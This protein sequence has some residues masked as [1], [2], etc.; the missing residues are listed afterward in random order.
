MKK[1]FLI[2]FAFA[3]TIFAAEGFVLLETKQSGKE[4]IKSLSSA[5]AKAGFTAA[6]ERDLGVAFGKQ[7][8]QSD[9]E[10]Y[11]NLTLFD[12]KALKETLPK[13]PKLA[14]FTPYTLLI[15]QKKGDKSSYVGFVKAK[16]ITLATGANDKKTLN[17][18]EKSEK[19]LLKEIKTA[20][21]DAKEV[22]T[23][24]KPNLK[25]D[26]E[27]FFEASI[28]LKEGSN[29]LAKKEALQKEFESAL[30]VEGFKISNIT[31]VKTELE[32][33]KADMSGYEFFE[34]YSICKLK[35]IYN[36]AKERP[37]TGVFAPCAVYFYKLK[38]EPFI[39][40]GFPPTKNWVVHTNITNSDYVKIMTE[41][42]NVV[43]N[44]LNEAGE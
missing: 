1:L 34:T 28:K 26:K 6:D 44:V 14:G 39:R 22:K 38:N 43:K 12:A 40:V 11:Y 13:N 36:A 31:D 23:A 33:V 37:E 42:E 4:L 35:V 24:Y 32:K 3:A 29:A 20:L 17:A 27:L 19:T 8:E 21:K 41:A 10:L 16:A 25:E 30:E 18:L 9:F 15:Y 5:Y 2:F 7:F